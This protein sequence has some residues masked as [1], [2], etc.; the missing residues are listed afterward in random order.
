MNYKFKTQKLDIDLSTYY[1][2]E[3]DEE[4][5]YPL[6]RLSDNSWTP[7]KAQNLIEEVLLSKTKT[8]EEEYIWANEELTLY[9][10][11]LGVFLIDEIS[12]RH[13]ETNPNRLGLELTHEKFISFMEDFKKF[14]EENQ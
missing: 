9:S 3:L 2:I 6:G 13:R 5:N 12:I 4:K 1:F 11:E 7:K 10:N 8:K 14:I